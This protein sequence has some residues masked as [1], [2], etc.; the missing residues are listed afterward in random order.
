MTNYLLIDGSYFIFYRYYALIQWWSLA[1]KDIPL[2]NAIENKEFMEKFE[3]TFYNKLQEIPKKLKIDNPIVMVGKDCPRKNIWR[4]GIYKDYKANRV[5]DDSFM[6]GP[7]FKKI[8]DE[9]M[10]IKGG[11]NK[12][13]KCEQLEADDCIAITTSHIIK[14]IPNA[15][16]WIITSDMDY[17]QLSQPNVELYNLKYTK[18][19][20]SKNSFNDAEKDLFCKIVMGDK[21]DGIPGVLKKCGIKTAEKCYLDNEYFKKKLE[22]ENAY[23]LYERNKTLVDFNNIPQNLVK[24]FKKKNRYIVD[25]I[26]GRN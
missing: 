8:Y 3:K 26:N 10:F 9:N 5:Y 21:S 6:G 17:L 14:L 22:N 12:I 13:L 18:L 4:M 7:I 1:N 16:I 2:E 20:D 19:T 24:M 11:V 25:G 23:D 15:K